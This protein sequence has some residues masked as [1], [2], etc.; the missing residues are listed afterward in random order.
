MKSKGV[1]YLLWFFF[2]WLGIHR[3]YCRKWVTGV[4]WLLTFGL[5][6]IGW[7][8]D[9]V[10]TSTLVDEANGLPKQE[11][12]R[13]YR[14]ELRNVGL[15][16]VGTIGLFAAGGM[17]SWISEKLDKRTPAQRER[18]A[19]E[20]ILRG[21]REIERDFPSMELDGKV[22]AANVQWSTEEMIFIVPK[23]WGFTATWFAQRSASV[24][25][26]EFRRDAKEYDG[27]YFVNV[28][29]KELSGGGE[30]TRSLLIAIPTADVPIAF[31]HSET[32]RTPPAV[33]SGDL[34]QTPNTLLADVKT[35]YDSATG[36]TV[37]YPSS[38]QPPPQQWLARIKGQ[39][40]D[41]KLLFAAVSPD[42]KLNLQIAVLNKPPQEG[43]PLPLLLEGF[44]KDT[45]RP[46]T[47]ATTN[48]TDIAGVKAIRHVADTTVGGLPAR[49][50][51]MLLVHN[52]RVWIVAVG[53]S[54][55]S[56]QENETVIDDILNGIKFDSGK[57]AGPP[58]PRS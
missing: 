42:Q 53:G 56:F 41:R 31:Q 57:R 35:H 24:S 21:Y 25:R 2:G 12:A 34:L 11:V 38:W 32:E 33:V 45:P 15:I 36:Y 47:N 6:G 50:A 54:R 39:A 27:H 30:V 37:A 55:V 20:K 9:A 8:L 28:H 26:D 18:D 29:V 13:K 7:G 16:A 52:G 17:I 44:L 22:V 40:T 5:F 51:H 43:E 14:K 23:T 46:R 1:A 48:F 58:S 49:Y 19:Q 3:F 10:L 4:L